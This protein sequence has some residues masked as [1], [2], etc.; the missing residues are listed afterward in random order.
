ML[1]LK[2]YGQT[3][4]VH[5]EQLSTKEGLSHSIVT[6][7]LQDKEGFM[8]IGTQ[9]G[10]NRFD[11]YNFLLFEHDPH[12]NTSISNNA[13]TCLYEDLEGHLWIGTESGLN[14]FDKK[15]NTF[16]VYRHDPANPQSISHDLI[17]TIYA[18]RANI[19]WIGNYA[20][21]NK[22]NKQTNTCILYEHA[23]QHPNKWAY[24]QINKIYE[25]RQG[26]FWLGTN[27]GISHFD[28]K[29][30]QFTR[31]TLPT[32]SSH[33]IDPR[34]AVRDMMEDRTGV[35]WVA[36]TGDGLAAFDRKTTQF[37]VYVP[38]PKDSHSIRSSHIMALLEDSFGTLWIG[39]QDKGL[40]RFDRSKNTFI[41]NKPKPALLKATGRDA[42][43]SIYE[44]RSKVL[45]VGTYE[46]GLKKIDLLRKQFAHL[47]HEPGNDNSIRQNDVTALYEDHLGAIWIGNGAGLDKLDRS[48]GQYIHYDY[49]A[50]AP[51]NLWENNTTCIYEDQAGHLWIG[52]LG[53]GLKKFDRATHR[54]TSY[55]HNPS[56]STSLPH[57]LVNTIYQDKQ[58]TLWL[59]T[60]FGLARLEEGKGRFINYKPP[61]LKT[62]A[63]EI[64]KIIEDSQGE[65]WLAAD[66]YGLMKFNPSTGHFTPYAY[67]EAT[68]RS[69]AT[70]IH[71]LYED[72]T[73]LL[74]LCLQE[75]GLLC[76]NSKTGSC[77]A[78]M[79][80]KALTKTVI[81]G[82]LADGKGDLWLSTSKNGLY[83]FNPATAALTIYDALDGLQANEFSGAC[84]KSITGEMYFGG[85]NGFN[86]FHPDSIQ[87]NPYAPPV[88][89][90]SFKV[91]DKPRNLS[92]VIT[93]PYY[94]NFLSFDFVA[95]S[96]AFPSKNQY[97]YQ[98]EGFD[99]E[100]VQAG[101]RRY[102][103][104]TNL[105][106]G[107]Y[108]FR[109]KAANHDGA[110][111]EKGASVKIIIS[112]PLWRTVGAYILYVAL[113][114]AMMD[115][116]RRYI[117]S[118]ERLKNNLLLSSLESEKLMELDQL[119][120]RFFTSISHELR[121][122]LTLILS[123]LEKNLASADKGRFFEQE[124]RLMHRNAKRL[125]E[126]IN[127]L[128]DIS[129]LE[130]KKMQW[131]ATPGDM[132][133]LLK[134][135][136]FSFLSLAESKQIKLTFESNLESLI[137]LFDKDKLEKI[138]TNLLA[139]ALK[140]TPKGEV[141]VT[142][143][144]KRTNEKQWIVI[145]V[146][147]TGIGIPSDRINKIFDRFYQVDS[148]HT[149][150]FE[151]TG[152]GLTLTK[153]LVEL[154]QGTIGV[155]ST[156]GEGTCFT[157]ELPLLEVAHELL[158]PQP[159][160]PPSELQQ[161]QQLIL[162]E[163]IFLEEHL[164]SPA[165]EHAPLLLVV[166]DNADLRT[167]IRNIFQDRYRIIEA[168]NGEEGLQMA[169][170]TIP[171][172]I[173]SDWMMPKMDGVQLCHQLKTDERT[174]HIPM[175]LLTAKATVQSKIEGLETGADDYITKPF[176]TEEL[177][178]R[179]KN[180]IA[181]R[182]SL[183]ERWNKE[184]TVAPPVAITSPKPMSALTVNVLDEK[185]LQR[186]IRV[187]EANIENPDFTI[188]SMEKEVGM[189]HTNL[190]R[191]V[192]AL[193]NQAPS[194]F[195][196][197]YRLQKAAHLLS[198]H[199]NNVSEVA[200]QVGFANLSYFTKCFRQMYG[201]TPSEYT[202]QQPP[203][204]RP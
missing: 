30:F 16:Q 70:A 172:L 134:A 6:C 66:Q 27:Q 197:H 161:V 159:E 199:T 118:Q 93:L 143:S 119:K 170:E 77:R 138:I 3:D 26:N 109:V 32:V 23:P 174:S 120:S 5:F 21:L 29:S 160:Q 106:P 71:N 74:W 39:T 201:T 142:V 20:G 157:V 196:R 31:Y 53:G 15:T 145:A 136:V 112:P 98:L 181:Q 146:E 110:W 82:I 69:K 35:L 190:N 123:P 108:V 198:Q 28:R 41:H 141:K 38:Q 13:I 52:L 45:W 139:N 87:H 193:T 166:E 129:K 156:V 55:L 169:L 81:N 97:A 48:N 1:A 34:H 78:I 202:G 105:Q 103:S 173:V 49:P 72:R 167:Y 178:V 76:L 25:D 56:D 107:E 115:G 8:W 152:I 148:S 84:F 101:T 100:W 182:K 117:I 89:I 147:D 154:Q 114:I 125:L 128:L 73:G 95:L 58:G 61:F 9:D 140:F 175:I 192:K 54:F 59:G 86:I 57:A 18:D 186:V 94:D 79:E 44:D 188:E 90:S 176:H 162:E 96:Y 91:F 164:P 131:E 150:E 92:Q 46:A 133:P 113:F 88:A 7:T 83:H 203:I 180:L 187:I 65:L 185:F 135:T 155:T 151:G 158:L 22:F 24:N 75:G 33:D 10:L 121:T 67:K 43:T 144:I 47:F 149:R 63:F 99:Q 168:S 14:K 104:F 36:T 126:L 19:L 132:M 102:A 189:S 195:M 194:E 179:A 80:P 50:P 116:L 12:D 40:C 183:R 124:V 37:K 60:R 204:E 11:G 2:L 171:D 122:P 62:Q 153:E 184:F 17:R 51:K 85:K 137:T 163:K 42:V 165:D 200:Y 191:K 177:F 111:N 127:Q 130:A 68:F 4:N 64:T